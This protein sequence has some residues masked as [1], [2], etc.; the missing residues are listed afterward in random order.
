MICRQRKLVHRND[1]INDPSCAD[2]ASCAM[3]LDLLLSGAC[4][5]AAGCDG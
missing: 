3:T 5:V 2:E 4:Q 1:F